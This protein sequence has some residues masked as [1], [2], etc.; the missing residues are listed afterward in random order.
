[1]AGSQKK[2]LKNGNIF[3]NLQIIFLIKLNYVYL[4]AKHRAII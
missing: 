1:M 4:Q 3:Q 2:L